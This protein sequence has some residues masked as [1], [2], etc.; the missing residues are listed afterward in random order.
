MSGARRPPAT[1]RRRHGQDER[2]TDYLGKRGADHTRRLKNARVVVVV[3]EVAGVS[4]S[5]RLLF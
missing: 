3:I 1:L 2:A 5:K 4:F